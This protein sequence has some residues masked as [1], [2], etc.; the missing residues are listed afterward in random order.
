MI[1][2][3]DPDGNGTGGQSIW[4]DKDK[5]ID[6][7]RGFKNEI[8]PNL[9]NIRGALSMANAGPDTNGSQFFI[10]TN[11]QNQSGGLAVQWTPQRIIDAYKNGGNPSLDGGYTVFGQV[12]KGMDIVEKIAA[13]PVEASSGGEE[14]KPVTPVTVKTIRILQE[15]K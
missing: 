1:Q 5:S 9:Y 12:I 4:R 8:S 7:G 13:A 14:S 2:G 6:S 15:A 3:G 11:S 10:N